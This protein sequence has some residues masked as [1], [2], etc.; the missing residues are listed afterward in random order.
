M[1]VSDNGATPGPPPRFSPEE[2]ARLGLEAWRL[3]DTE[4]ASLRTIAKRFTERGDKMSHTFVGELIKEAK[5]KAKYLDLVDPATSRA[6]L[7]GYID[8]WVEMT[9]AA[10]DGGE[11]K[12][13]KGMATLVQLA[14]LHMQLSGAS[15]PT[16]LQVETPTRGLDMTFLSALQEEIDRHDQATA[17]HEAAD[18]LGEYD[19]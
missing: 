4:N 2:R 18:E 12:F 16:R 17:A 10:I 7:L 8:T 9:R 5:T 11:V 15:M 19:R 1:T 6:T 14:R 13:D 3:Q